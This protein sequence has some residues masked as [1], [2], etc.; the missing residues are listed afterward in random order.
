M[1]NREITQV[2]GLTDISKQ[3]LE[4]AAEKLGLS[5]R[6]YMKV[7]RVGRTIADLEQEPEITIAHLSEAL[8]YRPR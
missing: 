6:S 4:Q 8:Q 1:T 7:I 5:A 2:A 3:F